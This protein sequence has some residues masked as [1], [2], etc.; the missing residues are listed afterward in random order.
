MYE[1]GSGQTPLTNNGEHEKDPNWSPDGS[2][3]AFCSDRE[4]DYEI[5]VMNANG[6]GQTNLPNSEYHDEAPA[7]W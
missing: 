2:K 3:I 5:I 6:S 7:W 1:D 4:G